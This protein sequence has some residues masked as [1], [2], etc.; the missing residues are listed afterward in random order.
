MKK[1]LLV[2]VIALVAIY[3]YKNIGEEGVVEEGSTE[4][5]NELG[6]LKSGTTFTLDTENSVLTYSGSHVIGGGHAGIVD[7]SSGSLTYDGEA[8][9]AGEFVADMN[10]ITDSEGAQGWV[11]HARSADFFDVENHPEASFKIT[12]VEAAEDGHK[13]TGDLTIKDKT[14]EISFTAGVVLVGDTLT[15]TTEFQIDRTL[16]GVNFSSGTVFADLKENIIKD[17]ID[18]KLDLT[19]TDDNLREEAEDEVGD[20]VEDEDGEGDE[21]EDEEE[22]ES[23]E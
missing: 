9:T 12:G 18:L 5:Q 11:D 16:W 8:F 20:E 14:N 7:L 6:E 22:T 1:F 23:E 15:A 2:V 10:T 3:V 17:E 19:F 21:E 4:T 13:V